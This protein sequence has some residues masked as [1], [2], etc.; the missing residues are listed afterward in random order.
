MV[1]YYYSHP[2]VIRFLGLFQDETT[3]DYY[4]CTELLDDSLDKFLEKHP[5]EFP[6]KELLKMAL[7]IIEGMIYLVQQQIVHR[8]KVAVNSLSYI[9][10]NVL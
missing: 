2:R 10:R 9:D 4:F 6:W 1:V 7:T 5:N 8:G 3:Q